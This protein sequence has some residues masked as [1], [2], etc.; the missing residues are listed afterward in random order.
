MKSETITLWFGVVPIIEIIDDP[1]LIEMTVLHWNEI[2]K[3][4]EVMRL[5]VDRD[6]Y[7][8]GEKDGSVFCVAVKDGAKLAGYFIMHMY[9]HPHY[10]HVYC[11]QS[12][13]YYLLPEYRSGVNGFKLLKA[14]LKVAKERG[15][16]Y[17]F[18]STKVGHDHP[19]LMN[20]LGLKPR[21]LMYGG[22]L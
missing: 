9:T 10:Q 12:D 14:G 17:A 16:S 19:N 4:K 1:Q 22:P 11:A 21:D 6:H 13:I 3:D 7:L 20:T 15:A 8:S 5:N 2:A 18:V